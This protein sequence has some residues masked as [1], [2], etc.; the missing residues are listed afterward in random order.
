[1]ITSLG[2]D[3]LRQRARRWQPAGHS[4][5]ALVPAAHPQF[6]GRAEHALAVV[7]GQLRGGD[8]HAAGQRDCPPGRSAAFMPTRTFGAPQTVRIACAPQSTA[9]TAACH[10]DR[11]AIGSTERTSPTSTPATRRRRSL[12]ALHLGRRVREPVGDRSPAR[13]PERSTKSEI[14]SELRS[15]RVGASCSSLSLA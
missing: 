7:A 15:S 5:Q 13:S 12:E 2:R 10:R 11:R 4:K 3:E 9:T 1:M 14:Q 8:L 6:H